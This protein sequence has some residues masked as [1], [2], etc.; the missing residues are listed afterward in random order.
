MFNSAILIEKLKAVNLLRI[1]KFPCIIIRKI[2]CLPPTRKPSLQIMILRLFS[3]KMYLLYISIHKK[4]CNTASNN[5]L[6]NLTSV[7]CSLN[8]CLSI[9]YVFLKLITSVNRD[10][11]KTP[12]IFTDLNYCVY[13]SNIYKACTSAL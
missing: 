10:S 6:N 8:I 7:Y 4:Y 9:L 3:C 1:L 13:S 11:T 12:T 2:A 5:Q